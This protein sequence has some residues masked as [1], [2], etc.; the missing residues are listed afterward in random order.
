MGVTR[1]AEGQE[2]MQVRIGATGAVINSPHPA[3]RLRIADDAHDSGGFLVLEWW[4]ESTGPNEAGAFDTWIADRES[5][6]QFFIESNWQVQW[7]ES[8]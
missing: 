5:L 6:E 7:S 3:H 4:T 2:F 8:S 1:P